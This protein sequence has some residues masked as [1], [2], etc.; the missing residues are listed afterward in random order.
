MRWHLPDREWPRDHCQA[1]DLVLE[2]GQAGETY[3]VG[4]GV[5]RSIEEIA[6]LL[7]DLTGKPR[8]LKTIV[9]RSARPRPPLL[10]RLFEAARRARL[11]TGDLVRGRAARDRRLVCR[12]PR[13]VGAAERAGARA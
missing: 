2:R 3:N 6:D 5:E 7:L 4:S 1:I 8:S 13:L 11:A 10:P 12:Q 9:S